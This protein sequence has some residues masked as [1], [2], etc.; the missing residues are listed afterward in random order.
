MV[1][2]SMTVLAIMG[3]LFTTIAMR[4]YEYSY[5]KLCKQQA[6][7]TATSSVENFYT[8]ITSKPTL[9]ET[10]LDSLNSAIVGE[11]GKNSNI[12]ITTVRVMVGSSGGGTATTDAGGNVT[13][14]NLATAGFFAT[15]LGDCDLY[16]RYANAERTE[17]SIEAH[18]TYNG[19]TETSRAIIAR[20]NKAAEE[21]KKIFDNVFCLQS[22]ITTI[23]TEQAY[24]D[25][26]VSQPALPYFLDS[27]GKMITD[28]STSEGAYN[29]VYMALEKTGSYGGYPT[30]IP[31]QY[32][33]DQSGNIV[34]DTDSAVGKYNA[35]L[36]DEVYSK[37]QASTSK[38]SLMGHT[39]PIDIDGTPLQSGWYNDWAEIYLFSA[40]KG[41]TVVDGNLYADS[42]VLIGLLD[43]NNDNRAY[44]Q[45]WNDTTK[46]FEL[47]DGTPM[48]SES[49]LFD[50]YTFDGN[51]EHGF[52]QSVFFD[53][54]D[55]D[56]LDRDTSKFRINGNMYLWEDARIE[57]FDSTETANAREGVKN[58]I[59]A[60]QDLYIAG[61]WNTKWIDFEGG[62]AR[63][64]LQTER[65]VSIYGD[66]VVQGN[67]YI[68]GATIYGDVYVYGDELRMNDVTVYGNVYFD[69]QKF[70]G[71]RLTVTSG[72]LHG[73]ACNGGNVIVAG[74]GNVTSYTT[75]SETTAQPTP[76][77]SYDSEGR[78]YVDWDDHD[79]A[80][81]EPIINATF[82]TSSDT[83]NSGAGS[84]WGAVLMD[85]DI[86]GTLWSNVNTHVVVSKSE[87][88]L[89]CNNGEWEGT[90]AD[91]YGNIYCSR[92]LFIDLVWARDVATAG[93]ADRFPYQAN[94]LNSVKDD[95][96][97]AKEN[98]CIS[99]AG[100]V[101]ADKLQIRTNQSTKGS[102]TPVNTFGTIIAGKAGMYIDGVNDGGNNI[103]VGNLYVAPQNRYI[104]RVMERK[105]DARKV[106]YY[107]QFI[108][109]QVAVAQIWDV[110]AANTHYLKYDNVASTVASI[111][112]ISAAANVEQAMQQRLESLLQ[113]FG[114]NENPLTHKE[115][116]FGSANDDIW[117]NKLITIRSWSAPAHSTD[118]ED[119]E[120]GK[121]IYY[122]GGTNDAN[123]GIT[124]TNYIALKNNPDY[125]NALSVSGTEG[126][127]D[128]T[129][130]I[131]ES[132]WFKGDAEG[133]IDL[134]AFD[135]IV[136]DTSGGNIH[137]RFDG[138]VVIGKADAASYHGT[139]NDGL[140]DGTNVV[141][142]G[143]NMTFWYL[144]EKGGYDM[145]SPTL[146][147][148]P[149]TQIGLVQ[150]SGNVGRAYDGLY[151]VSNDDA[152]IYL[153][154]DASLNAFTYAPHGQLFMEPG[155][156]GGANTMNGCMAIE[157]L[158]LISD[159]DEDDSTWWDKVEDWWHGATGGQV[160]D[161]IEDAVVGQ[162]QESNYQYV[163]PPLIVDFGF[164][165]GD[166]DQEID[167]YGK[168]VWAFLGYY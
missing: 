26:Y 23:V 99:V 147:L 4:S 74:N 24:G 152:L 156:A 46:R 32:V 22:P 117:E 146:K 7:Y 125:S 19:Y 20:T 57:N 34:T 160:G 96:Q 102:R 104:Q 75:Y 59:Y 72:T 39:K 113:S 28:L 159:A 130:T 116:V 2:V 123:A 33:R 90:S 168:V 83:G 16:V 151:I 69:G 142:T 100:T 85:C 114:A 157:S 86:S 11:Q 21:L 62:I 101:Y 73:R 139:M 58:N 158:I 14:V 65:E 105:Y 78:Y 163:Q 166:F 40:G 81:G 108:R 49:D 103:S 95:Y 126:L 79:Y 80:D 155:S 136:I 145:D 70:T 131:K 5:A 143:G 67:A 29:V 93:S 25:I 128:Y 149:Y 64:R 97:F 137:I 48:Y 121:A 52:K 56:V 98:H 164:T 161:D 127:G 76:L 68:E 36:R 92:Y 141:L 111:V 6:Y 94:W 17:L 44:M 42:R 38:S 135:K 8:L 66:V 50:A 9:F 133:K 162:Y 138:D 107:F 153:G 10:L 109:D 150:A 54:Q 53:H 112:G 61:I 140:A 12:D 37:V 165:Y 144:Y 1:L 18:A 132:V 43:R 51:F 55:N 47:V 71:D 3:T 35:V 30:T 77:Q 15:Y 41:G 154:K 119:L 82:G 91:V 88:G 122:V 148:N 129:L 120:G 89:W 13:G 106:K 110:N 167:D 115:A 134:S 124:V 27:A 118:K 45:V 84:D 87:R 60:A 31:G 63:D